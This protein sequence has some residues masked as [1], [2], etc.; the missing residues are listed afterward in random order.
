MGTPSTFMPTSLHWDTPEESNQYHCIHS[1]NY[2]SLLS[3]QLVHA[4]ST[5]LT[6]DYCTTEIH[7]V[8]TSTKQTTEEKKK[9]RETMSYINP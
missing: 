2:M 1:R 4:Q 9:E 8:L 3:D 5:I 7:C 6:Q